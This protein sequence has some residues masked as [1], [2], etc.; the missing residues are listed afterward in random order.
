VI[1]SSASDGLDMIDVGGRGPTLL[2]AVAVPLEVPAD[3]LALAF[4]YIAGLVDDVIC[5]DCFGPATHSE[6]RDGNHVGFYCADCASRDG[7]REQALARTALPELARVSVRLSAAGLSRGE[8]ADVIEHAWYDGDDDIPFP[9]W[10]TAPVN[11]R[12]LPINGTEG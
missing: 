10:V 3:R 7:L 5:C 8:I 9:E 4:E 6:Q 1:T 12:Y 11:T 2:A